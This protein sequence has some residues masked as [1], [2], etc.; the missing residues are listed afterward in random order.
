MVGQRFTAQ[1]VEHKPDALMVEVPGFSRW[2]FMPA[3][4]IS[5]SF[6]ALPSLAIGAP[7]DILLDGFNPDEMRFQFSLLSPFI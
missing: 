7:L 3:T 5:S 1:V 6:P 2:G 4:T